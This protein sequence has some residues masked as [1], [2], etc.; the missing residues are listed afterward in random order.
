MNLSNPRRSMSSWW[1]DVKSQV[2]KL[3]SHSR[4]FIYHVNVLYFP[5][6]IISI[7]HMI[8]YNLMNSIFVYET[9]S[10]DIHCLSWLTLHPYQSNKQLLSNQVYVHS[11]F[12][13]TIM[14]NL[15]SLMKWAVQIYLGHQ[16][17][18]KK[19]YINICILNFY[20]M[21]AIIIST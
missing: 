14:Q 16:V 21:L 18:T 6:L 20:I 7:S 19:S 10:P 12:L 9:I 5:Q 3:V 13:L 8:N 4:S 17:V 15:N 1:D 2:I 11:N